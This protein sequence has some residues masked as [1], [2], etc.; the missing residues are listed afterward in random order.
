M[1]FGIDTWIYSILPL[2]EAIK[3]IRSQ[4][5]DVIEYCYDHFR[6]VEGESA[7]SADL[8]R[9]VLEV[10]DSYDVKAVQMHGPFGKHDVEIAS[11]DPLVRSK[12]L[13]RAKMWI[14]LTSLL[15]ADVL[16]MHTAIANEVLAEGS[17]AA[18]DRS[19]R[20]NIEVF[21]ELERFAGDRGVKIAVE[22]RLEKIFAWRPFDLVD[23][24]NALNSDI[25][26][27]CLDVGHA[28]VNGINAAD[29]AAMLR[30]LILATHLHDNDGSSDQHLP[31]LMGNID[32]RSLLK[33]LRSYSRPLILEI[34][35]AND[36]KVDENNLT[37]SKVA[38]EHLLSG[39]D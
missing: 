35:E 18:F 33:S 10:V 22:N 36:L 17:N 4:G 26:G 16:V 6:D 25:I 31:P 28:N 13:E 32:W 19:R 34:R 29:M 37:L 12:A 2:D 15:D 8:C 7:R 39:V 5:L 14:E 21:K 23:F 27:L 11:P 1:S 3:K 20:L 38:M 30:D 24:V 9:R